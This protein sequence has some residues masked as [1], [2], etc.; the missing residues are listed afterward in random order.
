MSDR[1][2]V[3][4]RGRVEQIG[5]PT[6]IYERP[7]SIFVAGFIGSANLLPGTLEVAGAGRR[8]PCSTLALAWRCRRSATPATATRSRSC[9][10][11]ADHPRCRR[12][13]RRAQPP[14]DGQG[15]HL[16]GLVAAADRRRARATPSCSS[17]SRWTRTRRS[18]RPGDEVSLRWSTGSAYLLRGRSE[19]IGATT[20]DVDEVQ[21]TMD[22]KDARRGRGRRRRAAERTSRFS[23]RGVLIGGGV[24]AA[25]AVGAVCCPASAAATTTTAA[26]RRAAPGEAGGGIGQGAERSTSST[27]PSTSTPPRTATS[28]RVDRF[29]D[30]TGHLRQLLRDVQRQQRGLRQGVRR[31]PR[32]RQPDAV[33]HRHADVLDGG[34]PQGQ[35]LAGPAAVQP[36]PQLRQPRPVVPRPGVGPRRQ[37]PPAVAGRDHRVRLQH[38]GHR[39]R[40]DAASTSCSTRSSRARSASSPRCATRSGW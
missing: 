4:S 10:A 35:G 9:C 22:G 38:L 13:R 31:L 5:T 19:I 30:A 16:P 32:R 6:E 25:G 3:M 18:L 7:A 17:P 36:D 29:Q 12:R 26:A 14:G 39:P 1:I 24:V 8:S 27:G 21:A 34:P 11:R 28:A 23:R 40:A 2:A 15:R 37:V 20:T 33:G